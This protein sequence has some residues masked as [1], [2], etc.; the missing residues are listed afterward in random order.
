MAGTSRILRFGAAAIVFAIAFALYL[1]TL[2]PTVGLTDSGE[3]TLAAWSLGNAHPPGFPLFLLL[4]HLAT[5]LPVGSIAYRT[6]LASAFFAALASATVALAA[7]ELLLTRVLDPIAPAS[8]PRETKQRTPRAATQPRFTQT[9]HKPIDGAPLALLMIGAGL[10]F[11]VSRTLWEYAVVTEVYALNAWLLAAVVTLML[12]WR[13]ARL[14]AENIHADR[15]LYA[16]ATLF[17]FALGVHHVTIGLSIAA[18]FILVWRTAGLEF[19]RSQKL[20]IAAAL[21]IAALVAIYAYLPLA[22]SH[23]TPMNWGNPNSLSRIVAHITARQY[24]TYLGSESHSSQ[25]GTF[26]TYLFRD[27]APPW[28]PL[29]LLAAAFGLFHAFRRD[30]TAFLFLVSIIA[31]DFAW[32]MVYPILN[33][34]DAYLIPTFLAMT[35]AATY[36]VAAAIRAIDTQRVRVFAATAMLLLPIIGAIWSWPFRDRSHFYVAHDYASN[37]LREMGPDAL[38]ITGDWQLYA[39]SLYVVEAEHPRRDVELIETGF[40]LRSWYYEQL[41]ARYPALVATSRREV[42]AVRPLVDQ[43]DNHNSDWQ[44]DPTAR[45]ALNARIDDLV[46]SLIAGRI[47]RG[48]HVYMTVETAFSREPRDEHLVKRLTSAYDVVPRGVVVELLPGHQARSIENTPLVTRGL[49]DGSVRYDE[50]DV[51]PTEVLPIYRYAY[52]MRGRYLGATK[53]RSE[54]LAAYRDALSLDP[55]NETLQR[56]MRVVESRR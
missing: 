54:A 12:R 38:L 15:W 51:V 36:G 25:F 27:V 39:P 31:A 7:A 48:G 16:A 22:A 44:N 5:M 23:A 2:A 32:V 8:N 35:L 17:G 6:N 52:L 29:S 26:F 1:R 47:A 21:S 24:R 18:L 3:L 53:H 19:F 13:R 42:D 37:A 43:F 45:T 10:L 55:D 49:L 34:L 50:D 11:A 14:S 9:P 46:L 28:L 4:T 41:A 20:L 30:R 33:D 40:L 56:E